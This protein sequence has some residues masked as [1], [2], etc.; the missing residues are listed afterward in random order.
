MKTILTLF[1]L[2]AAVVTGAAQDTPGGS[3]L[4]DEQ[5]E[6]LRAA[7]LDAATEAATSP[8]T[9]AAPSDS[10][11]SP[12]VAP[13]DLGTSPAAAATPPE[14]QEII[15]AGEINFPSADIDMVLDIYATYV[16]RTILRPAALPATAITLKTQTDLTKDE[17]IMALDAVLALNGISMINVG[18]KFVKA[19]PEGQAGAAGAEVSRADVDSLPDL[20]QYLTHV[21]Q[22]KHVKV[23]EAIQIGRAHV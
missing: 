15:S 21:V 1:L 22:L 10:P 11:G 8:E 2:A 18:D 6:A 23:S 9:T 7:A 4:T 5:A 3:E 14:E 13:P 12:A 19:V 17:L 20:G 16:N